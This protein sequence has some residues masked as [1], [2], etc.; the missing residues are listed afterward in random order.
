MVMGMLGV[1][2]GR[3]PK[4]RQYSL[5]LARGPPPHPRRRRTSMRLLLPLP[6]R[7]TTPQLVL[8]ASWKLMF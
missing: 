6:V 3:A 1:R 2:R 7:P 4:A 8:P 5:S